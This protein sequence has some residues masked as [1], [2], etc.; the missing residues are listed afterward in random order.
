MLRAWLG[1]PEVADVHVFAL[2]I[3]HDNPASS[4][5]ALAVGFVP[6]PPEPDW[7]GIV[8]HLLRR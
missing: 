5:C 2:G 8:H 7:E 4:R 1:H 6:D 3:D